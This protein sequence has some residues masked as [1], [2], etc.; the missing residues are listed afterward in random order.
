MLDGCD[1]DISVVTMQ[2]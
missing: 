2:N 1:L